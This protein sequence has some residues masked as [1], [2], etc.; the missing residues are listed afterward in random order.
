MA[1][2]M[3]TFESHKEFLKAAHTYP[4][5]TFPGHT[6]EHMLGMLMRKKLEPRVED[7][8][9][10]YTKKS[11]APQANGIQADS[12]EPKDY[13]AGLKIEEWDDLWNSAGPVNAGIVGGF[14]ENEDFEDDFTTT[15]REDGVENVATGLRRKLYEDS[16]E[17]E[18]D[19]DK[20]DED[21]MP[22]EKTPQVS[23]GVLKRVDP[24]KPMIPLESMLRFMSTGEMPKIVQ[25][26]R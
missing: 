4:L 13:W 1:Q 5:T 8:I 18:G 3:A 7:W 16:D 6:Q 2:L 9:D 20:M 21:G 19:E 14:M 24:T 10:E 15:E 25:T 22:N 23:N 12:R 26:N 11:L 17:E